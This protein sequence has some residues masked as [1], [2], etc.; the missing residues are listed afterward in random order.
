[1]SNY[2]ER[3]HCNGCG[4][5]HE[6]LPMSYG[7]PFPDYVYD[8]PSKEQEDRIEM[9]DDLCIIDD[10]YYFIRGCI[11]LPV[12]EGKDSFIWDVWVS[13][14]EAN[15]NKTIE[16]WDA[17]GREEELE[18]MFGWLSTSLPCYPETINLKTMV[19]TRPAGVAPYIELEPTE[20]PLALEQR[21]G[22]SKDRIK[23][24]AEELCQ[25]DEQN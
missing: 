18:P 17:E 9:Y 7:G 23:Q 10:E 14:S 2:N 24:I 6:E 3:Y 4:K 25:Q 16:Y 5:Y 19:H 8:I 22:I 15:F 21:N 1:M 11:E 13:L 12:M 20:H